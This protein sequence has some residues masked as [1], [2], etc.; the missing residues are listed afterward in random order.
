MAMLA[1]TG[2]TNGAKKTRQEEE[3]IRCCKWSDGGLDA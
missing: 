3:A 2:H 1:N